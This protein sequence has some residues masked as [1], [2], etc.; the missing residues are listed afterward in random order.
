VTGDNMVN[1]K[2]DIFNEELAYSGFDCVIK[3]DSI[4]DVDISKLKDENALIELK[5]TIGINSTIARSLPSNVKIRIIGGYTKDY[6]EGM[7]S[8]DLSKVYG[9]VTY[10]NIEFIDIIDAIEELESGIDSNWDDYKKSLYIYEYMKKNIIYRKPVEVEGIHKIGFNSRGRNWDSLTG[11]TDKMSTCNGYALIYQ[12]LLTRQGIECYHIGGYYSTP[13]TKR[14]QHAWNVVAIDNHPFLV[15][16]IWDAIAFEN[17]IDQTTR[18]G[19][20]GDDNY[21]FKNNGDLKNNLSQVDKNW[22]DST[23]AE[24]NDVN[25][26][27]NK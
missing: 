16:I 11:L 2:R 12:E 19:N 10:D 18:F 25:L 15:D 13:N 8:P 27:I 4:F 7:K 17:G 21:E 24:F 20:T 5:N 3:G 1:L 22:I 9:K 26:G 6:L 14:G 23:L